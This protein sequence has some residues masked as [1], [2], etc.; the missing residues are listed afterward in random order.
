MLKKEV[1]IT[2]H[3]ADGSFKLYIVVECSHKVTLKWNAVFSSHLI[4]TIFNF[5]PRKCF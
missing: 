5:L 2:E 1:F 3:L 4:L